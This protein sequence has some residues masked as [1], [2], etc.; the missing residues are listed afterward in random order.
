[1]HGLH[2]SQNQKAVINKAIYEAQTEQKESPQAEK[3]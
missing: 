1:M 3:C 2:Q